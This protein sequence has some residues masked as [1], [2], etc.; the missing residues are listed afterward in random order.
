MGSK[1]GQ[2]RA[3]MRREQVRREMEAE[4]ERAQESRQCAICLERDV[5]LA[6]EC[7]HQV[8]DTCGE[9]LS[10]CHIC[11][12]DIGRRLKLFRN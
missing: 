7:G 8:C 6:F 10:K 9:G 11:R 3:G 1:R 5:N 12:K 4:R 2:S